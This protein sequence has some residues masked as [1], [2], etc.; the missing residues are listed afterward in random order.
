MKVGTGYETERLRMQKNNKQMEMHLDD[1]QKITNF[2]VYHEKYISGQNH[3]NS[4]A[5]FREQMWIIIIINYN[6]IVS[7]SSKT[8]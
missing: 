7:Q 1:P 6:P 8:K 5:H 4:Y 2:A 3:N